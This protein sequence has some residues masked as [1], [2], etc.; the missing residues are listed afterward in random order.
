MSA[1][2]SIGDVAR[3][4]GCK[5]QTIRYYEQVGLMPAPVRTSGNQRRYEHSHVER[6]GFIRHGRQLGFPLGAI[7]DLLKLT[8]TPSQ[9]C[10]A[11]DGIARAQLQ[12]VTDR[13][14]RLQALKQEFEH[15]ID[16]CR[17]G[18]TSECRIIE[19]LSDHSHCRTEDH[20]TPEM[21]RD[22]F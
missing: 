12:E 19:V 11:V 5:V 1:Q 8:D 22:T 17:H 9:S 4:A 14:E 15:M 6:L 18:R 20:L 7:R 10:Q 3:E 21:T 2:Y 16:E 13:I